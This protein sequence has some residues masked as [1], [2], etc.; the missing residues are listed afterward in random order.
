MSPISV[1]LYSMSVGKSGTVQK[2]RKKTNIHKNTLCAKFAQ[3]L[4][5]YNL[6]SV[7]YITIILFLRKFLFGFLSFNVLY[8]YIG[9][10]L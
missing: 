3:C 10:L 5:G 4:Y 1:A 9:I 6:G 8:G 7:K 2:W